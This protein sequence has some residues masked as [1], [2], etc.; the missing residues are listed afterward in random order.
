MTA[1]P[2]LT[3]ALQRVYRPMT[4]EEYSRAMP[5]VSQLLRRLY[6]EKTVAAR[7]PHCGGNHR[8]WE[9]G[10]EAKGEGS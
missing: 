5:V 3:R 10:C 6:S 9:R 4:G 7:C 8:A 1:H 2:E